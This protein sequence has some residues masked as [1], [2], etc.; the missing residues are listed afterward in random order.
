MLRAVGE[1]K[2]MD[3]AVRRLQ[4]ALRGIPARG[5]RLTWRGGELRTTI[6]WVRDDGY[7]R[8][9]WAFVRAGL[10]GELDS[11]LARGA[12]LLPRFEDLVEDLFCLLFKHVASL[13]PLGHHGRAGTMHRRIVQTIQ[14]SK[15]ITGSPTRR[16]RIHPSGTT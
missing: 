13:W 1:P 6:H 15:A 3:R 9:A 8:A 10:G 5:V 7:D 2:R 11:V 4:A 16:S 14:A 12:R